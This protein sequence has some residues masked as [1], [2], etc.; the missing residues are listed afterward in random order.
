MSF[1]RQSDCKQETSKENLKKHSESYQKCLKHQKRSKNARKR[2]SLPK[3]VKK[4]E[5][6]YHSVDNW[7]VNNKKTKENSKKQ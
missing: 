4:P 6:A 1:G 7:T 3:R 5:K 2:L